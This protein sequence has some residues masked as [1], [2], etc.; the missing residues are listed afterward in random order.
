MKGDNPPIKTRDNYLGR[1]RCRFPSLGVRPPPCRLGS[2]GAVVL[3]NPKRRRLARSP[4]LRQRLAQP[5]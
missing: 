5:L 2:R 1:G 4:N 3:H